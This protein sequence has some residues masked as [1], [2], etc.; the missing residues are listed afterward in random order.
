MRTNIFILGLL[1]IIAGCDYAADA[2]YRVTNNTDGQIKVYVK[3]FRI[4][5]TFLIQKDSTKLLFIQEYRTGPDG[6]YFRDVS[7]D[8]E[9]FTVTKNDTLTST[10]DYLEN[11]AWDFENGDYSTIVTDDEFK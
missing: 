1:L 7:E 2:S 11:D 4:N 3:T 5:S 9:F 8:L 6:A 10:R